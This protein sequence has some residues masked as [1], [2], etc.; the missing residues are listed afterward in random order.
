MARD[1]RN[2][3]I[4]DSHLNAVSFTAGVVKSMP[5][6]L[7]PQT[8]S[9]GIVAEA[10]TDHEMHKYFGTNGDGTPASREQIIQNVQRFHGDVDEMHRDQY[11]HNTDIDMPD[12]SNPSSRAEW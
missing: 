4:G 5:T 8:E 12:R 11:T 9:H 6:Y 7:K 3:E 2:N 1:H 10:M